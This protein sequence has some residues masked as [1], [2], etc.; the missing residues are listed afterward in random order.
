MVSICFSMLGT[1]LL[2]ERLYSV[3][4]SLSPF[5]VFLS[6]GVSGARAIFFIDFSLLACEMDCRLSDTV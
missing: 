5:P 2:Y 6:L 4:L 1:V 3:A